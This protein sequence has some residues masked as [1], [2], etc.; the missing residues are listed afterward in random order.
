MA[1]HVPD[2]HVVDRTVLAEVAISDLGA[3]Q[4]EGVDGR[5]EEVHVLRALHHRVGDDRCGEHRLVDEVE[6][7]GRQVLLQDRLE[8]VEAEALR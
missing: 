4:R 7:E 8:A 5:V 3:D 2:R 6:E 1:D